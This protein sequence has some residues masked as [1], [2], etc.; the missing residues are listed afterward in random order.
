[1]SLQWND[2]L[3]VWTITCLTKPSIFINEV[4]VEEHSSVIMPPFSKVKVGSSGESFFFV[5]PEHQQI[6]QAEVL[7][8][9]AQLIE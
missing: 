6:A 5:L 4:E 3:S 9:K 8:Q 7:K 2:L 1:M